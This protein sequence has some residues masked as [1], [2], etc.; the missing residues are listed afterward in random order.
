MDDKGTTIKEVI[1]ILSKLCEKNP[2]YKEYEV[3]INECSLGSKFE[4]YINNDDKIIYFG[5]GY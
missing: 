4:C 2:K 1:E 5:L 3:G